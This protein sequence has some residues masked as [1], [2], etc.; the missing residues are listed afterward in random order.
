M[1]NLFDTIQQNRQQLAGQQAPVTDETSRIQKLLRAKS[2]QAVPSSD[3]SISNIG[4]Q[5][6]VAETQQQLASLQ[7]QVA[8]QQQAEQTQRAGQQ[9]RTQQ[10][11]AQIAQA[12]KFNTIQNNLR[13]QQLLNDLSRDKGQLDLDKDRG[14]LEQTAFLM[15]MQ[16]KQY[17]DQL[18]DIGKRRRL[19]NDLAFRDEMQQIAFKDSLDILKDKLG[20]NDVLAA[21]DR[22]FAKAMN[23]LSIEDAIKI[24]ELENQY[25]KSEADFNINQYASQAAAASKAA[26]QQAQW[27]ATGQLVSA[28]VEAGGKYADNQGKKEYYTTG[29]GKSDTS[30]EAE[31]YRK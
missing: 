18:Q 29:A 5:A 2:G 9:Q 20:K 12:Q 3:M 11:E 7:P 4:E 23:K 27:Q 31:K 13:T 10:A 1:A 22:E 8:I 28:G 17:T 26:S 15:S 16:D 21:N 6:A 30:Y 14:R 25:A 19:D 24:A